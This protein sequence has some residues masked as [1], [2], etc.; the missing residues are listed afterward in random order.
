MGVCGNHWIS[1]DYGEE[2]PWRLSLLI[3]KPTGLSK[4]VEE[5]LTPVTEIASHGR[6]N[7]TLCVR[8][9]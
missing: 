7:K 1:S 3:K 9:T 5:G 6:T 4:M 2:L 8:R